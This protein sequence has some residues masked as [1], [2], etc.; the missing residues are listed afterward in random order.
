[1][2]KTEQVMPLGLAVTL[3]YAVSA[4]FFWLVITVCSPHPHSHPS[5][6]PDLYSS[7]D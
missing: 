3:A 5:D 6:Q 7:R 1:M 2:L 4:A